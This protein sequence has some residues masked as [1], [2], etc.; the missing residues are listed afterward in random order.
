MVDKTTSCK[1]KIIS[2]YH[3]DY[4]AVYHVREMAKLTKK[5]HVTLL[6]HL[7]SLEKDKII[8]SKTAGKNKVYSLNLENI[9]TKDY[10]IISELAESI[11]FQEE[12]FL[13][14][15]I[16]TEIVKLNL[17]GVVILFGSYAKKTFDE[18]SDIDLFYLGELNEAQNK[19]IKEI[20][21]IYG[22]TINLKTAALPNFEKGLR[23]KDPL[24][25]EI[26]KN[27]ILLQN[28]ELFINAIWRHYYEIR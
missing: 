3:S 2:L 13:I 24:I 26:I 10:L 1:L 9:L 17:A 16:I 25:I 5:S 6:P 27:H 28:R 12:V 7:V 20:G 21:Y 22:K 19:K 14:K 4:R 18:K 15:K 8:I 23:N 11:Q